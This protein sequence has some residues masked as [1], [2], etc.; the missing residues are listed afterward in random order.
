MKGQHVVSFR[1]TA[2]VAATVAVVALAVSACSGGGGGTSTSA[3]SGSSKDFNLL[4]MTAQSGSLADLG[5][6]PAT[7]G[8]KTMVK[9]INQKGGIDG[10]QIKLTVVDT[11]S[12]ATQAVNNLQSYL[13][14][15]PKPDAI[16]DGVYS[17]EALPMAPITT[18]AGV[19]SFCACISPAVVDVTKFP[20]QFS[21][22]QPAGDN[23]AGL[24]AQLKTK[25]YK[26]VA[27]IA[28]DNESGHSAVDT[29][30]AAA[31]TNGE[32]VVSAF[33]PADAV[34]ATSAL[35]SLR[36]QNPDVLAMY[37][38]PASVPVVLKS[39]TK[40]GWTI[41]SYGDA[42]F[43]S[44]PISSVT[45]EADWKN[46]LLQ[47]PNYVVLGSAMAKQPGFTAF[48]DQFIKDWGKAQ[49]G[50]TGFANTVSGSLSLLLMKVAFEKAKSNDP[51]KLSDALVSL[52]KGPIPSSI[53]DLW[54]G[55]EPFGFD[56]TT[57]ITRWTAADYSFIP[58]STLQDGVYPAP[59]K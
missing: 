11:A 6:I 43:S 27:Y 22:S 1:R 25:G 42:A 50:K 21:N 38:P 55:P 40:L 32:T 36:S 48:R 34:D 4:A 33:Y 26:K 19:L 13:A 31:K 58:V 46:V 54:I 39:R 47:A 37:A 10:R 7:D 29:F 28:A 23:A 12:D 45:S 3:A 53:A 51:K 9:L 16:F 30:T 17:L 57:H 41:P 52:G 59:T 18:Q 5:G 2:I 24:A 44:S 20:Y 49:L 35:D 14:S 15:N 56:A 8:I